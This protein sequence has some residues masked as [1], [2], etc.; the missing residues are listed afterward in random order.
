MK[1]VTILIV[2][3]FALMAITHLVVGFLA[4]GFSYSHDGAALSIFLIVDFIVAGTFTSI[5]DYYTGKQ[6]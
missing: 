3:F 5:I 4:S 2:S 1:K 6:L